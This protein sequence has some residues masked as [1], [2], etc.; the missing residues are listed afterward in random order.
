MKWLL[1][2]FLTSQAHSAQVDPPLIYQAFNVPF[3]DVANALPELRQIGITHVQISPPQKSLDNNEWWARYQPVDYQKIEGPLGGENEIRQMFAKAKQSG[4]AI[5]VDTVLNHMADLQHFPKLQY[6]Q[7]SMRD[8]HYP[9]TRPCINNWNSRFEVTQYWLCFRQAGQRG[10][11]PDLDTSSAY[12]RQVHLNYLKWLLNLGAVGFRLDAA[13]HIEK[14]YFEF[15]KSQGGLGKWSYGE[16]I[17][18][19]WNELNEY[20]PLMSVTDYGLLGALIG[21]ISQR[22]D[23]RSLPASLKSSL[24]PHQSVVFARTHDSALHPGFFNF[25]HD[26]FM[27]LAGSYLLSAS[28]AVPLLYR[29]DI[30][31]PAIRAAIEFRRRVFNLP[32]HERSGRDYCANCDNRDLHFVERGPVAWA[33][34]NKSSNWFHANDV[35]TPGLEVGIYREVNYGFSMRIAADQRGRHFIAQWATPGERG[36]HIGP[37]TALFFVKTQRRLT[38]GRSFPYSVLSVTTGE[39][40]ED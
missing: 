40:N 21:I 19:N 29:D 30:H 32:V 28:A 9:D 39:S 11:L 12:V 27:A 3:T 4:I 15:L 37:R 16:V 20:L 23:M 35:E 5:I 34:F 17:S 7:F 26:D 6:P 1:F 18:G 36:L 25:E 14:Q 2:L 22:G 8:F 38:G 33:I 31:V 24:P 13:K 10:G